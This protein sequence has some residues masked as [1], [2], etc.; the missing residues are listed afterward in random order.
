MESKKEM[1]EQESTS[2]QHL[3]A[4]DERPKKEEENSL[5]GA[6][7]PVQFCM[8]WLDARQATADDVRL[9]P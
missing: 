1:A 4:C 2:G 9:H 5:S 6:K 3:P 7:F 8:N